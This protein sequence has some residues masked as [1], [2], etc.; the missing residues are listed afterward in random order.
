MPDLELLYDE[1]NDPNDAEVDFVESLAPLPPPQKVVAAL[2]A[3]DENAAQRGAA[4]A[5]EITGPADAPLSS[6]SSADTSAS[7]T[8]NL[9]VPPAHSAPDANTASSVSEIPSHGA[10]AAIHTDFSPATA[11]AAAVVPPAPQ[12]QHSRLC[13]HLRE[14]LKQ[15]DMLDEFGA[16]FAAEDV[17][18]AGAKIRQTHEN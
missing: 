13:A 2:P 4:A 6:D 15:L 14:V 8:Q 18:Y 1:D 3:A 17:Q 7:R 16:A 11:A 12:S 5:R 10:P 9:V